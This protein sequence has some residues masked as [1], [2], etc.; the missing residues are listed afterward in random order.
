MEYLE[1]IWKMNVLLLQRKTGQDV[2]K[3]VVFWPW[4]KENYVERKMTRRELGGNK[5]NPVA[6]D[7]LVSYW[8]WQD[9]SASVDSSGVACGGYGLHW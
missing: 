3:M 9:S 5:Y 6:P 8:T 1:W 2:S 4:L 7:V